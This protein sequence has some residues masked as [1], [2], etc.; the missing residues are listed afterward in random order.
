MGTKVTTGD[1]AYAFTGVAVGSYTVE[2]TD[3]EG[4][5]S[6]TPNVVAIEVTAD[7]AATAHFGDRA[8]FK[9][10]L[11]FITKN[12]RVPMPLEFYLPIPMKG[13]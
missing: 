5:V 4:F 12:Y 2:E 10:H 9:I 3:P 8:I 11:P 6:T 7:G 1:G 13:Y